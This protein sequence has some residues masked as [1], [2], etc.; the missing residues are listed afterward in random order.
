MADAL[1]ELMPIVGEIDGPLAVFGHSMGGLIGF[2]LTLSLERRGRPVDHLFLS[3]CAPRG[4]QRLRA[5]VD[6]DALYARL[7]IDAGAIPASLR[8]L[9][10]E[11]LRADLALCET[12][13]PNGAVRAPVTVIVATADPLVP[14]GHAARWRAHAAGPIGFEP[15]SG[16]HDL[17]ASVPLELLEIV[18]GALARE[19]RP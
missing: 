1:R 8:A 7:G 6:D 18:T 16:G 12:F 3:C 17:L 19:R 4:D 9:T 14:P 10:G 15:V 11:T 13:R 5:G 2:E